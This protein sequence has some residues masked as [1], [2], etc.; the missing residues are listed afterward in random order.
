MSTE[1]ITLGGRELN[2]LPC[3]AI[4][5][6][7]IGRNIQEIGTGSEAGIDAL[8]DGIYYGIKRGA[9]DDETVTRDF[10]EWNID[11][12]NVGCLTE[13][14]VKANGLSQAEASKGEA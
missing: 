7:A 8:I 4:G 12:T 3:P 6:K 13:A 14:F 10:V 9:M 5:L 11:S 1:K 2:L